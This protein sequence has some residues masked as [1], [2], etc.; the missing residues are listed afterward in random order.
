MAT[1]YFIGDNSHIVLPLSKIGKFNTN[2]EEYSQTKKKALLKSIDVAK[3]IISGEIP[4]EKHLYYSK[5]KNFTKLEENERIGWK[6]PNTK[7]TP[8]ENDSISDDHVSPDRKF[9]DDKPTIEIRTRKNP[10][11]KNI[12]GKIK[13]IV[14]HII[15]AEEEEKKQ[16]MR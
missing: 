11:K 3:K 4:F 2:L 16:G 6:N 13:Y 5:S 1:V 15:R 7:I 9:D 12:L 10:L 8:A 14:T